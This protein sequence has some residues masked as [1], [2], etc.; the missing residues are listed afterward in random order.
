MGARIYR[1]P[2]LILLHNTRRSKSL[3]SMII[4]NNIPECELVFTHSYKILRILK[5]HICHIFL[6]EKIRS[7]RSRSA[8]GKVLI[9]LKA[10]HIYIFELTCHIEGLH[11]HFIHPFLSL[12]CDNI[13]LGQTILT[14]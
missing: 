7:I 13:I 4:R 12:L 11:R 1:S 6:L 8:V 3:D 9:R 14:A 10:K 2:I 5:V